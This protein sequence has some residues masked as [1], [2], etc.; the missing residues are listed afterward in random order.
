M[1]VLT[2]QQAHLPDGLGFYIAGKFRIEIINRG[3]Q[4]F[5]QYDIGGAFPFGFLLFGGNVFIA[6][7]TKQFYGV[8]FNIG[9]VEAGHDFRFSSTGVVLERHTIFL[10]SRAFFHRYKSPPRHGKLLPWR[11]A[12]GAN[13]ES[14]N[15]KRLRT[16]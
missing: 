15:E 14:R 5:A 2:G 13:R 7:L 9:F 11:I 12:D 8:F 3:F 4:A 1:Q 6:L 10:R 16:P